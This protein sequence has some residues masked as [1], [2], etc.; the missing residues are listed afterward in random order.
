MISLITN[1]LLKMPC[2]IQFYVILMYG[3]ST[4]V[5]RILA[6]DKIGYHCIGMV[7]LMMCTL[8][9]IH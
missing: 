3:H 6:I 4:S 7:M 9:G 2:G 1:N 5:I 8:D